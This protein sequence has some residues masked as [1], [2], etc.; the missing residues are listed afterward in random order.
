MTEF[1]MRIGV[2]ATAA[3]GEV[4]AL[5]RG[6]DDL[7]RSI[8]G[9]SSGGGAFSSLARDLAGISSSFDALKNASGGLRSISRD[10]SSLSAA[11]SAATDVRGLAGS[12]TSAHAA[13][14]LFSAGIA[15]FSLAAFTREILD[16]GNAVVSFNIALDSVATHAGEAGEHFAFITKLSAQTGGA[17]EEMVPAYQRVASAMRSLGRSQKEAEDTFAGFQKALSANHV[18]LS[19]QK[20]TLRELMETFAMGGGHA[21]QVM[22]GMASHIPSLAGIIQDTLKID[23]EELHKKFKEGGLKPQEMIKI[24]R[25]LGEQYSAGVIEGLEHSQAQL[26]L[27]KNQFFTLRKSIFEGGFDSGLTTMLRSVNSSLD[28]IGMNDVGARIGEGFR[29][30]FVS[31]AAFSKTLFELRGPLW[32]VVEAGAGIAALSAA[33][34]L[35]SVGVSLLL[36]RT[37][38]LATTIVAV[39]ENWRTLQDVFSGKDAGFN[40]GAS[41]LG[42][43]AKGLLQGKGL[44]A[45]MKAGDDAARKTYFE[46]QGRDA[47]R[48]YAEKFEESSKGVLERLGDALKASM[49]SF[50]LDA[51]MKEWRKLDAESKP[52][53]FKSTADVNKN[54]S[55][56]AR[57]LYEES[58]KLDDKVRKVYESL[59]PS[60][61]ASAELAEN[62][63]K[64]GE[65]IGKRAPDKHFINES[66]AARMKEF[67]KYA[68]LADV[69]PAAA[70]IRDAMGEIK[71]QSQ[72]AGNKDRMDE[73][74]KVL[75]LKHELMSKNLTLAKDE[76]NAYRAIIRAQQEIAK[77]GSNGFIQWANGVKQTTDSM[78]DNIKSGMDMLSDGLTK[79]VT[80]GKGKYR[81]LGEAAKA[82]FASI[83]RGMAS[84]FIKTGIEGL[85]KQ[86]ITNMSGGQSNAITKALGLGGAAV[87]KAVK[88]LDSAVASMNVNAA[89]VNISGGTLPFGNGVGG[90]NPASVGG[91]V[92][93]A[94]SGNAER[95]GFLNF[96][97]TMRGYA[98]TG[99]IK[100]VGAYGSGASGLT[101]FGLSG[102][103]SPSSGNNAAEVLR[104]I[105]RVA[106][107]RNIS[108][109]DLASIVS[110]E[111]GGSFNTNKFG[112]KGGNYLGAIQ[113]GPAE[114][115]KYGVYAGMPIDKH[116]DA[117]GAFIKDRGASGG[118]L[119]TLYR[120]INGG[121]PNASLN[122]SDGN[123]TI[124]SHIEKIARDHGGALDR[125]IRQSGNAPKI[126]MDP[127]GSISKIASDSSASSLSNMGGGSAATAGIG[128]SEA[129]ASA[130][131]GAAKSPL[132]SILPVFGI[133][134]TIASIIMR[135]KHKKAGS[136]AEGGYSTD[137]VS[138]YSM[139][140]SFWHGAPHYSEG[141][142]NTSGGIPAVLHENEAVIPLSRGREIPVKLEGGQGGGDR[143][144]RAPI[145]NIAISA[146]DHDGFRRSRAQV[147]AALG[148]DLG[149]ALARGR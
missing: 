13:L 12:F 20:N 119:S 101:A 130:I 49:P 50:D 137:A 16:T 142:P 92:K 52:H 115:K 4:A 63:Q 79:F 29:V 32:N 111:T 51:Y 3:K 125:L 15:G 135:K 134:G 106:T 46:E 147:G 60:V 141:T 28:A 124:A 82:E 14:K 89:V 98:A 57:R 148:A 22:R 140:S 122:A 86:A 96:E 40:I 131:G 78:N 114:Q 38:L 94:I 69:A 136:F 133:A 35:A 9:M 110:Y 72:F 33:F 121:N 80:E 88:G 74:L 120:T 149:R 87:D 6:F 21:T 68:A 126:D 77:G 19:E 132:E 42:G 36:S 103:A 76:E 102:V 100:G 66:E 55:N 145:V 129:I 53:P 26:N 39:T 146:K 56:E 81:N 143:Q 27:F 127:T 2:D 17:L 104:N 5:R 93:D 118:D 99:A 37:V 113:F 30:A 65:M 123:G 144:Q 139:P 97:P 10:I 71:I 24:G 34:K 107:E 23:G 105:N 45:A 8:A 70:K 128:A 7:K 95:A 112:G 83:A 54:A 1:N 108:P 84:K 116:F 85:M 67:A 73:E 11:R 47:G 59:N 48:G 75:A 64:I 138:G 18:P 25:A 90:F 117:V 62:F 91:N 44:D 109:R 61:K 58:V 31:T 41:Y 43:V